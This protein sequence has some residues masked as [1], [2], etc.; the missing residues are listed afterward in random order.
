[1]LGLMELFEFGEGH[2]A[3][4]NWVLTLVMNLLL[5]VAG[6]GPSEANDFAFADATN[7]LADGREHFEGWIKDAVVTA[8]RYPAT[9]AQHGAV[10]AEA[11]KV[12]DE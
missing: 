9:F 4:S 6:D 5:D 2:L 12:C 10:E 11:E 7:W 3:E 8:R 1:V